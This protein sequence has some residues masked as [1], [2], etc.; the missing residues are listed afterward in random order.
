MTTIYVY[1]STEHLVD[2]LPRIFHDRME[3]EYMKPPMLR[4]EFELECTYKIPSEN[5]S[6]TFKISGPEPNFSVSGITAP[7]TVEEFYKKAQ[8][9]IRPRRTHHG[10]PDVFSRMFM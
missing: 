8:E 4:R 10:K 2:D 9:W 1:T 6:G 5:K 3:V 7:Y